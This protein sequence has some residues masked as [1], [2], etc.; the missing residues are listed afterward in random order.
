MPTVILIYLNSHL[1]RIYTRE[2]EA[3]K[4]NMRSTK[5]LSELYLAYGRHCIHCESCKF[6]QVDGLKVCSNSSNYLFTM[7][8]STEW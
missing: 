3:L 5:R 8:K 7:W 6:F 4:D 1:Y 2:A